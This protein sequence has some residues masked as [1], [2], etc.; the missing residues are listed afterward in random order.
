MKIC[1]WGTAAAEGIPGVYCKCAVC[2]EAREKGERF[3]RTRSQVLFDDSLMLDFGADTYMHALKYGYN[4]GDL[5]NVII[6]H[7]HSDHFYPI[8]LCFRAKAYSK[9]VGAPTLTVHGSPDVKEAF[10]KISD[11]VNG[12]VSRVEKEGRV[13]F[14][15]LEPYKTYKIGEHEVTPMPAVHGTKNPYVYAIGK[16]GKNVLMLNDT[17]LLKPEVIEFLKNQAVK[18]DLVSYDCTYGA[19]DTEK[20]WGAGA[21][22]MGLVNI[23]QLRDL[24]INIGICKDTTLHVLTHF[25]HNGPDAGYADMRK[26]ACKH[27]FILA[28][29]GYFITL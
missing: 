18:F 15:V 22:H 14:N 20:D 23:L 24:L 29:D 17:G 7:V 28:Y 10:G 6:S 4:L 25:S 2:Q 9:D 5:E 13:V 19:G 26:H 21:H 12:G 3:V 11:G 16:D 8:E 1:Y 27:G